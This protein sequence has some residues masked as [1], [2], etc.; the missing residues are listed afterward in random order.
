MP[1]VHTAICRNT[2]RAERLSLKG[3][4]SVTEKQ[5]FIMVLF[6]LLICLRFFLNLTIGFCGSDKETAYF[7]FQIYLAL[8]WHY[9]GYCSL[10][11]A[12]R[13]LQWLPREL[14]LKIPTQRFGNSIL[15]S[16]R[17]LRIQDTPQASPLAAVGPIFV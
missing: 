12:F 6:V 9:N 17:R 4:G 16:L 1:V 13:V 5:K 2:S 8:T 15:R 3:G 7:P 10:W 14:Q 11:V